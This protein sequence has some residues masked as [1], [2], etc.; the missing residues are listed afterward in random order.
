MG[1]NILII[2]GMHRSGTSLIAQ[3]L[4]RCGL[5]LGDE[6]LG[7]DI[8]N[9]DGHFEDVDF[10]TLHET[11]LQD[12]GLPASGLT[13][14]YFRHIPAEARERIKELVVHK[15]GGNAAFGWKDPRTCLFLEEYSALFPEAYYLIVVR[16]FAAVVHSLVN[17]IYRWKDQ[18]H[19]AKGGLDLFFW[20]LRKGLKR[21]YLYAQHSTAFLKVW[22]SYNRA[23]LRHMKQ[24]PEH[25]FVVLHYADLQDHHR[26]IF[27][28]IQQQWQ[29]PLR[30]VDFNTVFRKELIGEPIDIKPYIKS[31]ALIAEAV[32]M[33]Q[34]LMHG[35]G[36]MQFACKQ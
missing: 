14:V 4:Y 12:M 8:T 13:D 1:S 23:L 22:L 9:A 5:Q 31:K 33:E 34:Q 17:R 32:Q 35:V 27:D 25:R 28:R 6:F 20:N 3:W 30:Y 11:L 36:K 16:D 18:K 26:E 15:S 24:V 7:P 10:V 2:A 21:K 19:Q 29:F